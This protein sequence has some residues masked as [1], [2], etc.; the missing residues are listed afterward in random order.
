MSLRYE[1]YAS[2]KF[3]VEYIGRKQRNECIKTIQVSREWIQETAP[4]DIVLFSPDGTRLLTN[5][6]RGICVWGATSGELIAGPLAG[7]HESDALSA[8]YSSDGRHII[9][10]SRDGIIREWDALTNCLVWERKIDEGQIDLSRVMS[11]E[12]SPDA[13]LLVLGDNQGSIWV[14]K[15]DTGD[16]D[17]ETLKGHTSSVI[18][19]S[20]SFDGRYLASGSKD[21]TIIIWDMNKRE[22]KTGPFK[23]YN[24]R[25]TAV[26]FSPSGN[27]VV[28]GSSDGAVFVWNVFNGE[29]LREIKCEGEVYSVTSSPNGHLL[30]A[31]GL[32]WMS[33]W[34]VVDVTTGSKVFQV[35]GSIWRV[36]F[37]SD[38][39]RFVSASGWT[40][41][42]KHDSKIQVVERRI[43][44]WDAT[45]SVNE[46]KLTSEE[47]G[48]IWTIALSPSGKFI[49]TVPWGVE[50]IYLWDVLNGEIVK[51]KK[52][53]G[54]VNSVSFSPI[55]DQLIAFGSNDGKVRVWDV[56]HDKSVTIGN[57]KDLVSSVAFSPSDE[58]YVASGSYDKTI[59]I[60]DVGNR[61]L[62]VGPLTGHED[63]VR[64]VAYSPDGTRLVSG[65]SD[66]TVRIW[67]SE[68]G[69]L[70]S[71]FNGHSELVYSVAYSSDGSHIV[72]GSGNKIILVW[73]VQSGEIV[74]EP[75]TGHGD[76]VSSV[77]FSPD[78]KRIL[79]GSR[80]NT[81]R[82]WDAFTGQPLFPSFRGHTEVVRTVCF[83][84][85]GRHFAT[86]SYDGAIRI[87]TLDTTP[88]DTNWEL[89]DDNWIVDKNGE[90][91]M[92]I[93]TD[94]H[95]RLYSHR[96]TSILKRSYCLKL[97]LGNE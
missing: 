17:G 56:T 36:S 22:K 65:S 74:G 27:S 97:K 88:N 73:N 75:I 84:P 15:V 61:K 76:W 51:T 68:T 72:S 21:K 40:Y 12:F 1:K 44:T 48:R 6:E 78:G 35:E 63:Y 19:L 90:L 53:G 92:W 39:N 62:G 87:W 45:W 86:G 85:D 71:T 55:N 23:K 42:G 7:D 64:A 49:V 80:D 66:E 9:I 81:A 25:V 5:S 3:Q 33:M 24:R 43:Q 58:T 31:G 54:L 95:A 11:V 96:C 89:R 60:W 69:Q 46:T 14:W 38:S 32:G 79:S 37:S 13:K 52:T 77:C 93:P 10:A 34:N 18:C 8:T 47:K 70:L 2:N 26:S 29:V 82:I 50:N 67:N 20:F 4:R 83:F 30:L 41:Y 28:S 57:H 94:L 16:R 59:C 91:M